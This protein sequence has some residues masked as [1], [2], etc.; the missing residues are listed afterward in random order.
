MTLTLNFRRSDG[1]FVATVRGLPYHVT[2]SDPL[3]QQASAIATLMGNALPQEPAPQ[4]L[5]EVLRPVTA[6]QLRLWLLGKGFTP[7]QITGML[8]QIENATQR[9]AALIE[10]EYASSYERN[11]PLI[12]QVGAAIGFTEAQIDQ[13][14]REARVL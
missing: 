4:P 7:S 3:F 10:W 9:E 5:P 8:N 13:G 14:F 2:Q 11:H 12:A 1:S 6:R